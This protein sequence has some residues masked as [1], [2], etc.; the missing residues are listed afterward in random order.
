[1]KKIKSNKITEEE[2]D[3]LISLYYEGLSTVE[4][5]KILGIFLSRVKS[6]SKYDTEKQLFAF[7]ETKKQKPIINLKKNT[8]WI[9]VAAVA[10]ICFFIVQFWTNGNS[11]SYA[12][13]DGVK[14]TELSL[15]K[16]QAIASITELNSSS[17]IVEKTIQQLN[18]KD[19]MQQQLEVFSAFK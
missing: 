3:R 2:A 12:Y 9:N 17:D 6:N 4:E 11:Q 16:R 18:D 8:T 10:V 5:E 13:I 1:M 7:F 19:I 15:I 14:I